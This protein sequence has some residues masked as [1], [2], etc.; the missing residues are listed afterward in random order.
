MDEHFKKT[1]GEIT[2]LVNG[3]KI[4]KK[5]GEEFFLPKGTVHSVTNAF[6]GQSGMTVRYSPCANTH[7]MFEILSTLDK[8]NTISILYMFIYFYPV[9]RLELKEFSIIS[10]GALMSIMNGIITIMGKISGWDKLVDRF[11]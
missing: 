7:R 5:D 6:K 11:R 10:P 3:E 1:K 9:P 8:D 2:F 4:T